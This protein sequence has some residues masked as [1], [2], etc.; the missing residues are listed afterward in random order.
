MSRYVFILMG[1]LTGGVAVGDPPVAETNAP[2]AGDAPAVTVDPSG[3]VVLEPAT[4]NIRPPPVWGEIE[5][6]RNLR[7]PFSPPGY[8]PP[9][10]VEFASGAPA[11]V[12]PTNAVVGPVAP[13]PPIDVF[14]PTKIWTHVRIGSII[15]IKGKYYA[16]VN[17]LLMQAGDVFPV[18]IEGQKKKYIIRSINMRGIKIEPV[19]K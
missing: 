13:L 14:T 9:A 8:V 18:E 17:G 6:S 15:Q 7:D 10:P 16:Y 1:I 11:P 5:P 19:D 3:A 12:G 4:N 2:A